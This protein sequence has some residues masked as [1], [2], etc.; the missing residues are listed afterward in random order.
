MVMS[1][2]ANGSFDILC[3]QLCRYTPLRVGT[4]VL[5]RDPSIKV[6]I[7][8]L[9]GNFPTVALDQTGYMC[10]RKLVSEEPTLLPKIS[11]VCT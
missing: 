8:D 4:Y 10:K 1:C 9:L 6:I 5:P 11:N 7:E 3:F 2:T